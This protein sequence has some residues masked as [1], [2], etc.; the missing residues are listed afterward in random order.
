MK[1]AKTGPYSGILTEGPEFE[2]LYSFGSGTGVANLDAVIAAD[3]LSDELGWTRCR[4][5]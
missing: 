2:T 3:R 1:L 4:Q 5:A